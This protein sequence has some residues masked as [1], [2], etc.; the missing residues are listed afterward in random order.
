MDS[1]MNISRSMDNSTMSMANQ[2]I[3][4]KDCLDISGK[5]L[6]RF[7]L[8]DD[9]YPTLLSKMQVNKGGQY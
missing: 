5:M 6:D 4:A 8:V 2:S 7:F 3:S 9:S 1:M